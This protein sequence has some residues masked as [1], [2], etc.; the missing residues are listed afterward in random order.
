MVTILRASRTQAAAIMAFVEA[1]AGMMFFTTPC[2]YWYVTPCIAFPPLSPDH[3]KGIALD[4]KYQHF[5]LSALQSKG[6]DI[7]Q[8]VILG[9]NKTIDWST[10]PD[11]PLLLSK[12]PKGK[13]GVLP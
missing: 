6:L 3:H 10:E 13:V 5:L 11:K 2:V 1:T 4:C 7:E 12:N 8:K 9:L